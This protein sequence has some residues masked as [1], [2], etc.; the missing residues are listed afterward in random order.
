[1]WRGNVC[2]FLKGTRNGHR[3]SEWEIWWPNLDFSHFQCQFVPLSR[4]EQGVKATV[5]RSVFLIANCPI[6]Y[7]L[8][9]L[10][11]LL[12]NSLSQ[13]SFR[14]ETT[15]T[16]KYLMSVS[17]H[18]PFL[19]PFTGPPFAFIILLL[20]I[21]VGFVALLLLAAVVVIVVDLVLLLVSIFDLK[22]E[23]LLAKYTREA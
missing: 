17:T 15:V 19:T 3:M 21:V 2:V 10:S 9:A 22:C 4:H 14:W 7:V 23:I 13:T 12:P 11:N 16:C 6:Y 8:S 1:M 20:S 5:S 18:F